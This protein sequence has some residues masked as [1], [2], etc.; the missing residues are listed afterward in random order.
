MRE[1][2]KGFLSVFIHFAVGFLCCLLYVLFFTKTGVLPRFSLQWKLAETGLLFIRIMP[3]M[4]VSSILIGYAV[5]FGTCGQ[6]TV[7]R[8]SLILVRYLKEAF[9]ILFACISLYLIL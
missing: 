3:A 7:E 4:L 8:Y 1:L 2:I 9:I 6:N 5:I